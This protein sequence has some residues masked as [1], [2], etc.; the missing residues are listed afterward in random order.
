MRYRAAGY[1]AGLKKNGEVEVQFVD[2]GNY[3]DVAAN[4]VQAMQPDFLQLPAQALCCSLAGIQQSV[5]WSSAET[6]FLFSL[7]QEDAY[8]IVSTQSTPR[9][10]SWSVHI[11]DHGGRNINQ[12]FG[13]K[14]NKLVKSQPSP[15]GDR[16]DFVAGR[17]N[18]RGPRGTAENGGAS[19]GFQRNGE[20]GP[21]GGPQGSRSE[22][23]FGSRPDGGRPEGGFGGRPD[24]GRPEGG[25]GSRPDGGRPGGG[26]GSRPDGGRPEG[27]FGGRPD[28]GRPEG[29]FGSRPDGG[30]PGGGFGSRPDGGRPEGG[31]GGR[32]ERQEGGFQGRQ[33][34]GGL[35]GRQEGG[36]RRNEGG[37]NQQDSGFGN[38]ERGSF[39]R[40]DNAENGFSQRSDGPPRRN[41]GG[42]GRR[43]N[44]GG[45]QKRD[46]EGGFQRRDNEGGFQRR[47]E[48]G[49]QKRDNE[50][51]FQK[52]DN[53][54]GFQ[55]R[56]P[57]GRE[58]GFGNQARE[59]R[60]GA[61]GFQRRDDNA[62]GGGFGRRDGGSEQRGGGFGQQ[63]GNRTP[64]DGGNNQSGGFGGRAQ[65]DGGGFG[66]RQ[67]AVES[68][69]DEQ[70]AG[71]TPSAIKGVSLNV[72]QMVNVY[73]AFVVNPGVFWCQTVADSTPLDQFMATMRQEL[74]SKP[75]EFAA[76]ASPKVGDFCY[77]IFSD[78]DQWYRAKILSVTGDSAE[79]LYIDYGNSETVS[80]GQLKKL[81]SKHCELHAVAF[82]CHLSGVNPVEGSDWSADAIAKLEELIMEQELKCKIVALRGDVYEVELTN[83]EDTRVGEQLISSGLAKVAVKKPETPRPQQQQQPVRPGRDSGADMKVGQ[84]CDV[85]VVYI[86]SPQSF[87]CQLV[88]FSKDLS[89]LM[90]SLRK[91]Y[92]AETGDSA[93][94]TW[95][96][97]SQVCC[98]F[99]V[100]E[101]W[102]RGKVLEVAD[103]K[104]R[105]Y[106]IDYGNDEWAELSAVRPLQAEFRALKPMAISCTLAHVKPV[107][108]SEWSEEAIN[109]M[110]ELTI[111]KQLVAHVVATDPD[112]KMRVHLVDVERTNI[113][114]ELVKRKLAL[115]DA[116]PPAAQQPAPSSRSQATT[117]ARY[118]KQASGLSNVGLKQGV[119]YTMLSSWANS[120]KDFYLQLSSES[121]ALSAL[122][123]SL[124]RRYSTLR[125]GELTLSSPAVGQVC[126]A[127]FAV[128]NCWYRA[129]VVEV[130]GSGSV[131]VF[132]IDYG[133]TESVAP[134]DLKLL[135]AEFAQLPRQA[136]KC[137][138][139]LDAGASKISAAKLR[140]QLARSPLTCN[141]VEIKGDTNVMDIVNSGGANVMEALKAAAAAATT[142]KPV[143]KDFAP[144]A[145][146]HLNKEYEV[147][148][149]HVENSD[150][151]YC[152]RN[153][154]SE[155][156][157]AVMEAVKFEYETS[158][159]GPS[160]L[161]KVGQPCAA[162]YA[163][164]GAWYRGLVLSEEGDNFTV[165][166]VDYGN[167]STVPMASVRPLTSHLATPGPLA[168]RCS[169]RGVPVNCTGE[170]VKEAI[171]GV[172]NT[173]S[174]TPVKIVVHYTTPS[175]ALVTMTVADT[176]VATSVL[177]ALGKESTASL[178][179]LTV[180]AGAKLSEGD[181]VLVSSYNTVRD[182][183]VQL[184]SNEE[185]IQSFAESLQAEYDSKETVEVGDVVAG[186]VVCAKSSVD[187]KWYRAV[188]LAGGDNNSCLV[189]FVDNGNS[190]NVPLTD[191][192]ILNT[193]HATVAAWAIHC[194][195][196][197]VP[198]VE[199]SQLVLDGDS[200]KEALGGQVTV[201]AASD[202]Q[203][204]TVILNTADGAN[205]TT[206]FKFV[207]LSGE[208]KQEEKRV[209]QPLVP[210]DG[211]RQAV[212]VSY[213]KSAGVVCLQLSDRAAA[214]ETLTEVI[215]AEAEELPELQ[216]CVAGDYSVA[217]FSE[218]RAWY[219]AAIEE[220][221]EDGE[222]ATVRFVDFGN[223][224][225]VL[226]SELRQLTADLVV[227]S[228]FA[229]ECD[230]ALEDGFT[231][232][233]L[234]DYVDTIRT[235]LDGQEVTADFIPSDTARYQVKLWQGDTL[236]NANI[237]DLARPE[238]KIVGY[239]SV[240]AV[241]IP[242][243]SKLDV[244]VSYVVSPGQFWIQQA[245]MA[246]SLQQVQDGVQSYATSHLAQT[247]G[248][249]TVEVGTMCIGQ[250][251]DDDMWY[252]CQVTGVSGGSG[253]VAV[254]FIDFG[255]S[256]MLAIDK[257]R[258]LPTKY[259]NLPVQAVECSLS[260]VEPTGIDWSD[261]TYDLFS[262][263][264]SSRTLEA[265]VGE[266]SETGVYQVQLL[267][268]GASVGRN[269]VEAGLAKTRGSNAVTSSS[270]D[271]TE[272][273]TR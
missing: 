108:G 58:G 40:R 56:S 215:Q 27:G 163:E 29:G 189:T 21:R 38:N 247:V 39:Q 90:D 121:S 52:R 76:L 143:A 3:S 37:P 195:L 127:K 49:F 200:A 197:G 42:F 34:G 103:N 1:V 120:V 140:A 125:P 157:D 271:A 270:C 257:L 91:V 254:N 134:A 60:G 149:S 70:T 61:G 231:A 99:S 267:H 203:P 26:F 97:G 162:V 206:L 193:D 222:T 73:A 19:G 226:T 86:S 244:S 205:I 181:K 199:G 124:F 161:V 218:D 8:F 55:K 98:K 114:E 240:S 87:V 81:Q 123:G 202:D 12:I 251:T 171:D 17:G 95:E 136:F 115:S 153:D 148:V 169:L 25:F 59:D 261:E 239:L 145:V 185:N 7:L 186:R 43:E 57:G 132:F 45:F 94:Q 10:D 32:Q 246:D 100:D 236:L 180:A 28:G 260:D 192:R 248:A 245:S 48:G 47:N 249:N 241:P 67:T 72:G 130:G 79:V 147:T 250:S 264:V 172:V 150:A 190:G 174:E 252:R 30:R 183:W 68:W 165:R 228:A 139:N 65:R 128:D 85:S 74:T 82:K 209:I 191:V 129:I 211:E 126:V 6:D 102:Y 117:D 88:K 62:G 44:D 77:S 14:T 109:I 75:N 168:I 131:R 187:S 223:S 89:S 262:A 269:L 212:L 69:G 9:G 16:S 54:G 51:G 112:G 266:C 210:G 253:Q 33:E 118:V 35:Q 133:N 80:V 111:D 138:L 258:R 196:A 265:C 110:E 63:G 107:S 22:G 18:E 217:Q 122:A 166:F 173:E 170:S 208:P 229:I 15:S 184:Q 151:I 78:D 66:D 4:S 137:A 96:V 238:N 13:Q 71:V 224:D 106:F 113:G 242:V 119:A 2:F 53:E 198:E 179:E 225:K 152:Q 156:L 207:T 243:S 31:F 214:L 178:L 273:Q 141:V 50:G 160:T 201:E 220:L 142:V 11:T 23:G 46:G 194:T 64:R 204:S 154:S 159:S 36:F 234:S 175:V 255:N 256:E 83:G 219:R 146:L 155:Q 232:S 104:V 20:G 263:L 176:E 116:P 233:D 105:V 216:T 235:M 188:V 164:D 221:S 167:V 227:E 259:S 272:Q 41:E 135:E 5:A 24:G 230:F 92:S 101:E 158:Q 93:P 84:Y 182:F 237:V 268:E 213:V 144:C 177:T